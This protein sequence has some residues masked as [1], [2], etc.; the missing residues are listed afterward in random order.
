M[1]ISKL[2]DGI[3]EGISQ[4]I[5][6]YCTSREIS[7]IIF[8]AGY[9]EKITIF[10]TKWIFLYNFFKDLNAQPNGQIYIICIIQAF[11]DSERWIDKELEW[12]NVIN[13]LNRA[14]SSI[15]LQVSIR[16]KIIVTEKNIQFEE[17]QKIDTSP[18]YQDMR[19]VP[20]FRE[21]NIKLVS[22][23]CFVLMPFRPSFDRIYK[24]F[25]QPTV[26]HC[27]FSC[28]K[29]DKLFSPTPIMEDIWI[30]ICKSKVIV[31]DIT[32]KNPNVFYEIGI[33]HTL[34]K[35]VIMITQDKTDFPFDVSHIRHFQYTDDAIGW[36]ALSKYLKFALA[37]YI[38]RKRNS[39]S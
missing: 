34:G 23:F 37:S 14:L 24:D 12:T 31:A 11:C 25:I 35:P 5:G 7:E 26:W 19:V 8:K 28:A 15:N 17:K 3:F 6:D 30:Q 36:D 22:N 16:G 2:P 13:R 4:T 27:G 33:A 1:R 32:G 20:V 29:A 9:P 21:R 18:N 38:D 10:G 39:R